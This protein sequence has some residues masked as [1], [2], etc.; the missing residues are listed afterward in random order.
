[1]RFSASPTVAFKASRSSR[2]PRIA[3][4]LQRGVGDFVEKP[5][6]N[7][8]LLEILG[9][10][11]EIG[12]ARRESREREIERER[13]RSEAVYR[14]ETQAREIDEALAIQKALL[15]TQIPQI[16][17]YQIS[18]VWQPFR[19]V[20][21]DY[22]DV[23]DFEASNLGICIADVA[24][25]GIAAAILMANLQSAVR[26]LAGANTPPEQLCDRLNE[27]VR[28][29][30]TDDRFITF[31]YAHLD[32]QQR[33]LCYANAGHNAPILVHVDG[34]CERLDQ[35][36][37]VLGAFESQGYRMSEQQ[38]APGDR[39]FFFTDGISEACAPPSDPKTQSSEQEAEEFGE[40]RL[41]ELI[42]EHRQE[43]AAEL[44]GTIL[45]AVGEYCRGNWNDDATLI[46]LAVG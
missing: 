36:G 3:L 33:K 18:A 38:L 17:G 19:K 1:M 6:T 2:S 4:S 42:V 15:P 45:K 26:G 37:G 41:I 24:G 32:G 27:L 13:T 7:T 46:V 22:Y 14:A 30:L 40:S 8:R 31:F 28:R 20:G 35:G 16:P 21:G 43:R 11:I 25:K 9:K 44:Q 12:R 23:L 39:L 29:N 34:S 5:W 10:Q